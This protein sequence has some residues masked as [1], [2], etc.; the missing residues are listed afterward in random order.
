MALRVISDHS[1]Q[2]VALTVCIPGKS[3]NAHDAQIGV[4]W[5]LARV[6]SPHCPCKHNRQLTSGFS[7]VQQVEQI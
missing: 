4:H 3:P 7:R 1:V 6:Q 5:G 2:D